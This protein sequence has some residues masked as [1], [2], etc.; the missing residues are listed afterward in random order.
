MKYYVTKKLLKK[1]LAS[2]SYDREFLGK[3]VGEIKENVY[4]Y[5]LY[6]V[7]QNSSQTSTTEIWTTGTFG[8]AKNVVGSFHTHPGQPRPSQQDL[9]SFNK[10]GGYHFI[11]GYPTTVENLKLY[12]KFGDELQF[13]IV[14]RVRTKKEKELEMWQALLLDFAIVG[15]IGL[16]ILIILL[17]IY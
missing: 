1:M 17:I 13:E 3:V 5:D 2:Y 12:N 14:D 11:L 6:Y 4:F 9:I 10:W 15:F 7:L 16:I 8:A